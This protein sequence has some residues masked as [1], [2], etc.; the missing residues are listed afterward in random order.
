MTLGVSALLDCSPTYLSTH[1]VTHLHQ[2]LWCRITTFDFLH[3]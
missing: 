1:N 2:A 3:F